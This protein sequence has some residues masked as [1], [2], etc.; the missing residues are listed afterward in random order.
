MGEVIPMTS[1]SHP[2]LP[3]EPRR[4]RPRPGRLLTRD[5]VS[6]DWWP[7]CCAGFLQMFSI[8][9]STPAGECWA[10][11]HDFTPA[12]QQRFLDTF[13]RYDEL[14]APDRLSPPPPRRL[15]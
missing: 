6:D 2:R 4:V 14:H 9:W 8:V 11:L 13:R 12:D 1:N 7:S 10:P 15:N 5:A 3:G